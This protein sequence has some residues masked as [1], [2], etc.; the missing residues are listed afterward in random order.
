MGTIDGD[1]PPVKVDVTFERFILRGR[2]LG[3]LLGRIAIMQE[4]ESVDFSGKVFYKGEGERNGLYEG[5][6]FLRLEASP[7][8]SYVNYR[9]SSPGHFSVPIDSVGVFTLT[10]N[11]H[12]I[13]PGRQ[14]LGPF[15]YAGTKTHGHVVIES[16]AGPAEEEKKE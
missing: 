2:D 11:V 5:K 3:E 6:M 4:G 7:S 15:L 10:H 8:S 9:I 13:V 16:L 12:P 1:L 14:N